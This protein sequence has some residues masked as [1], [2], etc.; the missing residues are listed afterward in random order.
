MFSVCQTLLQV[1]IIISKTRNAKVNCTIW[2]AFLTLFTIEVVRNNVNQVCRFAFDKL[3]MFSQHQEASMQNTQSH[4]QG[5]VT[6]V[7]RRLRKKRETLLFGST[8][9]QDHHKIIA[10]ST[11]LI[12]QVPFAGFQY[13][14]ITGESSYSPWT[15]LDS[16]ARASLVGPL[17]KQRQL[18]KSINRKYFPSQKKVCCIVIIIMTLASVI[19]N[20]L[21]LRIYCSRKRLRSA[22]GKC[23][24]SCDSKAAVNL[25][26]TFLDV[27][28]R[29]I[30]QFCSF[31]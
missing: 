27:H 20:L 22:I 14:D 4:G 1:D 3:L 5:C 16:G 15:C 23:R 30:C 24:C 29:R 10:L 21:V 11:S 12:V 18:S 26:L 13:C 6:T 31:T 28:S 19:S 25:S 7:C 9:R 17:R 2:V 8:I